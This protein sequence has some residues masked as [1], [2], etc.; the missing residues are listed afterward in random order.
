MKDSTNKTRYLILGLL[1]EQPI[2][3]YQIK[4]IVEKRFSFFWSES[5]GQIYPELKRLEKE[6]MIKVHKEDLCENAAHKERKKY[7]ITDIGILKLQKWLKMPVEKEMTRYE[8]LLKLYFS[9]HVLPETMI[10]HIREFQINH[11]NQLELFK[12]FEEDLKKSSDVHDNHSEV[13]MVLQ[14][15]KKV[16]NA[17]DEWCVETIELLEKSK[18]GSSGKY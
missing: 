2:S 1:S 9:N 4:K 14:F 3:G 11:R 12:K 5:Y 10:Q 13:L 15:G 7:A 18:K 16:W 17:Y 6:E 8:I